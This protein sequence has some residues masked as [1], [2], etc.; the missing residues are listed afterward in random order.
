MPDGKKMDGKG[1][2]NPELGAAGLWSTPTDL[3]RF[4]IELQESALGKS[5]KLLSKAMTQQMMTAQIENVGFGVFVDGKDASSRFSFGGSNVGFKCIMIGYL[6]TGQGA[7][8][9]TNS[10]N[11]TQLGNE[12]LRSISAEY[13]WPDYRPRERVIVSVNP[14]I[15]D[16][17]VG[18]YELVPGVM[19]K[20]TKEGDRLMSQQGPQP[21]SELFPESETRFF[22]KD[23]DA[24]F[25]FVK[26]DKG[27][28]VRVDIQRPT[29]LFQAK[30]V[31]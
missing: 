3:A 25:T 8:V 28:V 13:G 16:A 27:Q 26:D 31:Q 21:K 2:V 23:A 30:K 12:I 22:V 14:A 1:Y 15:F 9:M 24:T 4:V 7:V 10:E 6:N 11:G 29:R 18:E 20:V 17:Y 5:N 19:L